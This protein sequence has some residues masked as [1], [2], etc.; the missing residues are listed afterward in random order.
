MG[1]VSSLFGSALPELS[2]EAL[3]KNCISG[4][5]KANNSNVVLLGQITHG[6]LR[7]RALLF[8]YLADRQEP[9]IPVTLARSNSVTV[10]YSGEWAIC[11]TRSRS[12]SY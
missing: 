8:K 7:H 4:L 1:G 10:G 6:L 11:A 2:S 9:V 5:K 12:E 3:F